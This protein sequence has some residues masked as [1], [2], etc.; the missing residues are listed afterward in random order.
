MNRRL[1]DFVAGLRIASIAALALAGGCTG[2]CSRDDAED[3]PE[4][5]SVADRIKKDPEY[6]AKLKSLEAEQG[7][8]MQR[9]ANLREELKKAVIADPD[10]DE[11]K[12]LKAE[13][14]KVA[15]EMD[16]AHKKAAAVVR[17]RLARAQAEQKIYEQKKAQQKKGE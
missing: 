14:E 16:D 11:V 8:I 6:A 2:G 9:G 12:R 3:L 10:S 7:D 4:P 5:V 17:E 15:A 13:L 1:D